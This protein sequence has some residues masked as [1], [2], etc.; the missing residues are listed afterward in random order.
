MFMSVHGAGDVFS[1]YEQVTCGSHYIQCEKVILV[2]IQYFL[3]LTYKAG[4]MNQVLEMINSL[5]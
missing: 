3:K 5:H 4:Q 1:R 2:T